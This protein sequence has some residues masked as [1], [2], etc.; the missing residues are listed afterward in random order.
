[1]SQQDPADPHAPIPTDQPVLENAIIAVEGLDDQ[2]RAAQIEAALRDLDGVE[3][4][5]ADLDRAEVRV[6]FDARKVHAPS[7]HDA[8]LGTGYHPTAQA[9]N[10]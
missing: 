7:L 9:D 3:S 1:M 8:I 5:V 10:S 2:H 4:A 6:T